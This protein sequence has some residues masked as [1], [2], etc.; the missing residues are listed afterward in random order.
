MD[1]SWLIHWVAQAVSNSPFDDADK[2]QMFI[3]RAIL[4][5]LR[6]DRVS[7]DVSGR[8]I[9]VNWMD[10]IVQDILS[11]C[12]RIN[13]AIGVENSPVAQPRPEENIQ[14]IFDGSTTESGATLPDIGDNLLQQGR[15]TIEAV[16]YDDADAHQD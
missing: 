11:A 7:F 9:S 13:S 8:K 5:A 15:D 16:D 3:R 1:R 6:D 14:A 12:D 2:K 10:T 4:E